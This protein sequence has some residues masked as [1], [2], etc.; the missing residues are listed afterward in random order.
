MSRLETDQQPLPE[1]LAEEINQLREALGGLKSSIA[2][3]TRFHGGTNGNS[4][5]TIDAGKGPAWIAVWI[6]TICC[7]AMM[8]AMMFGG[9]W[10]LHQAKEID[11][12]N[13]YLQAIYQQAPSL[14]PPQ[15][16][17]KDS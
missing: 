16:R 12:L 6:S 15:D 17:K 7:T 11:D 2:G 10:M 9:M 8:V 1:E 13:A 5:V 3:I 4:T 14:Q